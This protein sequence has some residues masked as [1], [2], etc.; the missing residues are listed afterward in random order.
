M[1]G[2]RTLFVQFSR[3]CST[4]KGGWL[5]VVSLKFVN[6]DARMQTTRAELMA[7]VDA[8][9]RY[10]LENVF[11]AFDLDSGTW[12]HSACRREVVHCTLMCAH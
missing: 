12:K 7:L 1:H 8:Y 11:D 5:C 9:D 6:L 2:I 3:I 4:H 10:V